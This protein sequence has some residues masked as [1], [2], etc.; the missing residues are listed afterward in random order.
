[1]FVPKIEKLMG[2]S[3]IL[4]KEEFLNFCSSLNFGWSTEVG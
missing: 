3:R 4:H 1:M 2:G